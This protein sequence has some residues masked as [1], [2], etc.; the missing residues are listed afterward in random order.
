MYDP[1][2]QQAW[3]IEDIKKEKILYE[4]KG[5]MNSWDYENVFQHLTQPRN[6]EMFKQFQ[7][8]NL[9][10]QSIDNE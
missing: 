6:E 10:L 8:F 2:F 5:V 3:H 1:K 7:Q 9:E 4:C